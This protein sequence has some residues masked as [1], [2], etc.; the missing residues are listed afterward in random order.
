MMYNYIFPRKLVNRIFFIFNLLI[1]LNIIYLYFIINKFILI[2]SLQNFNIIYVNKIYGFISRDYFNIK[3]K[4]LIIPFKIKNYLNNIKIYLNKKKIFYK[5][6]YL[7]KKCNN[8]LCIYINKNF[9]ILKFL[10]FYNIF[11]ILKIKKLKEKNKKIIFYYI[12]IIFWYFIYIYI[13]FFF[14]ETKSLKNIK[15][16]NINKKNIIFY[17]QN[18]EFFFIFNILKKI[19][20]FLYKKKILLSTIIHDIRNYLTR[21]ILLI[22]IIK[23]NISKKN[24]KLIKFIYKDIKDCNL[25]LYY[26]NNTLKKEK[27]K[28]KNLEK[29]NLNNLIN[30]VIKIFSKKKKKIETN[31]EKK[32]IKTKI[33]RFLIKRALINII[34]NAI[35]YSKKWIKISSGLKKNIY[36]WFQIEDD[37]PGIKKKEKKF[38]FKPLPKIK[39]KNLS[40][41][42]MGLGLYIVK[43]I[44]NK[45]LGK[46]KIGKSIKGGFLIKIF[47][48]I[49]I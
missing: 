38:L 24:K 20:N 49:K 25:L 4:Y 5:Y 13:K 40:Y 33:N 37:G 11:Y 3:N 48:P 16:N 41:Y 15:F 14:N 31:L 26:L 42:K 30:E 29:T 1:Y 2:P 36:I 7:K 43:K 44:I 8:L 34:T 23:K 10:K 46:I 45:H 21:F 28:I 9:Y 32:I 22:E 18:K 47:I 35:N 19:K 39:K 27:K 6:N 12:I 17:P